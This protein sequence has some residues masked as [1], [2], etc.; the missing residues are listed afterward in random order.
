[1]GHVRRRRAARVFLLDADNR[2]LLFK[3]GDPA[4]TARVWFPPGGEVEPREDDADAARRELRE[5][6]GI[7][8]EKL[9]GP[10]CSGRVVFRIADDVYDVDQV[11]FL[12]R[13]GSHKVDMS[14]LDAGEAR[15]I[16]DF[17]WWSRDEIAHSAERFVPAELDAVL[18]AVLKQPDCLPLALQDDTR[19]IQEA[20]R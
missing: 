15:S 3:G 8:V 6:T 17:R 18:H 12:A 20:T 11:F 13:T 9:V 5:E 10:V 7:D 14:G 16:A 1:M 2:V 4:A 19:Q